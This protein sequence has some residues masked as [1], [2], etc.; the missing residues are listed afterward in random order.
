MRAVMMLAFSCTLIASAWS[1]ASASDWKCTRQSKQLSDGQKFLDD[2]AQSKKRTASVVVINKSGLQIKE[3]F[4]RHK[5]SDEFK[6]SCTWQDALA[7]KASTPNAMTV[8]YYT[9][10]LTTGV[11]WWIV[12][13]ADAD[14]K[15]YITSPRNFRKV[16]DALESLARKLVQTAGPALLAGVG[17]AGLPVDPSGAAIGFVADTI[18]NAET[19]YDAKLG[20]GFKQKMLTA[21]DSNATVEIV[22]GKTE[23]DGTGQVQIRRKSRNDKLSNAENAPYKQLTPDDIDAAEKAELKILEDFKNAAEKRLEELKERQKNKQK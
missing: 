8:Y 1:P 22:I 10:W 23:P 7:D 19:T 2:L 5:Y 15:T 6:D 17:A 21:A 4:V 18:L 12:S 16:V 11:D 13:W 9:G 20:V 3:V 14:G